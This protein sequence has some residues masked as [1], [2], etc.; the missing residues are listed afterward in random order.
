MADCARLIVKALREGEHH[1]LLFQAR[2]RDNA[3][4]KTLGIWRAAA[5]PTG[6]EL[7][8]AVPTTVYHFSRP[9]GICGGEASPSAKSAPHTG[10]SGC[11]RPRS[12]KLSGVS[13]PRPQ[14]G[15]SARRP[16][17]RAGAA[18][19]SAGQDDPQPQP[20]PPPLLLPPAPP[21]TPPLPRSTSPSPHGTCRAPRS[22]RRPY[23]STTPS[24]RH[25]HLRSPR[26]HQA[27]HRCPMSASPSHSPLRPYPSSTPS[28][29]HRRS[30]SPRHRQPQPP[31]Q[32][33]VLPP[34][35]PGP[36]ARTPPPTG[37]PP[38]SPSGLPPLCRSSAAG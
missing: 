14:Q 24:P 31:P 2:L 32:V 5:L 25:H 3:R 13:L 8:L 17:G 23:P 28:P 6:L 15:P 34:A 20:P 33:H 9:S 7:G 22:P 4:A 1:A 27:R 12:G 16:A 29:R 18:H 11:R 21:G 37:P 26:R 38:T 30:R 19:G 10:N 35:A 36:R